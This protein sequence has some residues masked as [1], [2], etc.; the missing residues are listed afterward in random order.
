MTFMH[1]IFVPA[2]QIYQK[3]N[4]LLFGMSNLFHS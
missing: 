4:N 3:L 1:T 2:I